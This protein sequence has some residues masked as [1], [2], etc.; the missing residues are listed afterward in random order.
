M[1]DR[2]S[3]LLWLPFLFTFSDCLLL[4][5]K[6]LFGGSESSRSLLVHLRSRRHAIDRHEH[7]L[8]RLDRFEEEINVVEN[9]LVDLLVGDAKMYVIVVG[10][11]AVVN[12][13]G[14]VR[15]WERIES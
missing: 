2:R 5:V 8:S 13:T 12:H 10:V 3:P 11:T 9:V 4:F 7:H 1:I 14:W 6:C 15:G